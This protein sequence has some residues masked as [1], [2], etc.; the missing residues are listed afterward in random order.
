LKIGVRGG[1]FSPLSL[2]QIYA[3]TWA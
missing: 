3:K 2:F 1:I